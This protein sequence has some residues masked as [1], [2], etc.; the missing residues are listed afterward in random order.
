MQVRD[1]GGPPTA[2]AVAA[3]PSGAHPAGDAFTTVPKAGGR[4]F[5]V[6]AWRSVSAVRR[7]VHRDDLSGELLV[8]PLPSGLLVLAIGGSGDLEQLPGT[9]DVVLADLLRSDEWVHVTG[10]P[11]ESRGPFQDVDVQPQPATPVP[12]PGQLGPL[13]GGQPVRT[14]RGVE[15]GLLDPGPRRGLGQVEIPRDLTEPNRLHGARG[16]SVHRR[17]RDGARPSV[18]E[19]V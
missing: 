14:S 6:D 9:L 18:T 12:Q 3:D 1:C 8:G 15:F 16:R 5:G 7:G 2:W 19:A 4:Q 10:S 11:E 13:I 17:C